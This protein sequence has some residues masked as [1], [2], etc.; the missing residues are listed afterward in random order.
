MH[1]GAQTWKFKQRTLSKNFQYTEIHIIIAVFPSEYTKIDVGWGFAPDPTEELTALPQI[2][3]LVSRGPLRGRRG[4]E[5][6]R[7]KD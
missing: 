1:E 4:I 6:S 5:G 7:G 3:K 2:P